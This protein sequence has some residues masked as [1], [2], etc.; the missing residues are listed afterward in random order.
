MIINK[1]TFLSKDNNV[2]ITP[3]PLIDTITTDDVEHR[4]VS[5]NLWLAT[6][7]AK[8]RAIK[9]DN[10]RERAHQSDSVGSGPVVV[11]VSLL[12][13]QMSTVQKSLT[14]SGPWDI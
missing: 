3:D 13:T 9:H 4:W 7:L 5:A 8:R 10:V 2:V 14:T 12:H 1:Y 6:R 11:S